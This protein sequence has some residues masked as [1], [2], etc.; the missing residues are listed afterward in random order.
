[1]AGKLRFPVTR[2]TA[3]MSSRFGI[4]RFE[5]TFVERIWG[6]TKLRSVL[7]QATP[8]GRSIGES[9]LISDHTSCESVVSSGPQRGRT[10]RALL[11]DDTNAVLGSGAQLT[12][13][14]RFPL[15][16]KLIDT[17]DVL[18][19]QVHPDDAL[20]AELDEPDIGKTECWHILHADDDSPIYCGLTSDTDENV[21]LRAMENGDVD[22]VLNQFRALA[23]AT[24][25]VPAGTV[26]AIGR[27]I[28][29]AEIQQNSDLTYRVYDWNRVQGNGQ[30]REL[31]IEKAVRVATYGS[32]RGGVTAPLAREAA[33]AIRQIT[34]ACRYFAAERVAVSG[35]WTS[36]T[37]GRSF[38]MLLGVSG[39]LKV[40]GED[41]E[42]TLQPGDAVL[43]SGSTGPYAVEGTGQLLL[44]YVPEMKRDIVEPLLNAGH[45]QEQIGA[46]LGA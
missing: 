23:N 39:N 26:H 37:E 24:V 9:W 8:P 17:G 5:P 41:G 11:E 38:H 15:L 21:F 44:Y 42:E 27:G 45:S 18:S 16:L 28:L 31:H 34:A 29:L 10:L 3:D 7:G 12:V 30:G 4:L 19:V 6:G 43:V 14:G 20:A 32:Q 46:L 25:F 40:I 36:D 35:R 13:H 22:S 1:M 33:G 2:S